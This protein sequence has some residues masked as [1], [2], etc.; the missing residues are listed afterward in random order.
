MGFVSVGVY[1]KNGL[2][3][4]SE[5]YFSKFFYEK[6]LLFFLV[7]LLELLC[8]Q[9]FFANYYHVLN[10]RVLYLFGAGWM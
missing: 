8:I 9:R 7:D 4:L 2:Y 10:T 6:N 1:P 3:F 5:L